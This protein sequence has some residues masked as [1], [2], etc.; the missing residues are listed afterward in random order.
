MMTTLLFPH[1]LEP[2]RLKIATELKDWTALEKHP[3]HL[4]RVIPQEAIIT[5]CMKNLNAPKNAS[6]SS[7]RFIC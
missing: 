2:S 1:P 7:I 6:Q 4:E 3:F 5:A